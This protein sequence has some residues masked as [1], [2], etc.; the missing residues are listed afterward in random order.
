M[1]RTH[2]MAMATMRFQFEPMIGNHGR[3]CAQQS[4]CQEEVSECVHDL[5]PSSVGVVAYEF[6]RKHIQGVSGGFHTIAT[7]E[8]TGSGLLRVCNLCIVAFGP[9]QLG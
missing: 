6:D 8:P 9:C 1:S 3:Y 5:F 7:N 4:C 2:T